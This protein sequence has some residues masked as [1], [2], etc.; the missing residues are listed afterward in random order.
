[1]IRTCGWT[2][3]L[4]KHSRVI[5]PRVTT[6]T[7][8]IAPPATKQPRYPPTCRHG[9]DH[10]RHESALTASNAAYIIG[11]HAA[12]AAST[13]APFSIPHSFHGI[14]AQTKNYI[15]LTVIFR[16]RTTRQFSRPQPQG[17]FITPPLDV[18]TRKPFGSGAGRASVAP[19][20]CRI[21]NH[22]ITGHMPPQ[23]CRWSR[24]GWCGAKLAQ[25]NLVHGGR[26]LPCYPPCVI[27]GWM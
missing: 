9:Y 11:F 19:P 6:T 17:R 16:A 26:P 21:C 8:N 18:T 13:F 25:G 14:A 2:T 22:D 1:M 20:A 23:T 27:I 15:R 3:H 7:D 10:H 24:P 12:Y 4:F 5:V